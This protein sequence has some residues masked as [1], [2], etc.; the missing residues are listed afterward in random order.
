MVAQQGGSITYQ[1]QTDVLLGRSG[2]EQRVSILPKPRQRYEFTTRLTDAQQRAVL[3]TLG[4]LGQTAPV[5]LLGLS[6]EAEAVAS[7]S[8]AAVSLY[9][10][11]F[12]SSDWC[13]VGQRVAV[14]SPAGV[15]GES[16]ISSASTPT[17]T[18]DDDLSALCGPGAIIM[19]IVGVRLDANQS[20]PR[21]QNELTDWKVSAWA[22]RFRYG[23]SG[24]VGVG[25]SLTMFDSLP[26]WDRGVL[27]EGQR[28]EQILTGADLVD[29]GGKVA[30]IG[31]FDQAQWTRSLDFTSSN[32]DDWQWLKLFLDTIRGSWKSFLLR[33]YRPD[34]V[35]IGDASGGTLT[36][37]TSVQS[38]S[39]SWYPSLAHRRLAIVLSD[40]TVNYRSVA[41][42]GGGGATEDLVLS[43]ALAGTIA[44][45]EFLETV[46]LA[47]DEAAVSWRGRVF[48]TQ[49]DAV[50]VQQ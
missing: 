42:V 39:D 25:S 24:T 19:P 11:A 32:R 33:T 26:V 48:D 7:A 49:M 6:F 1:W 16:W 30:A 27:V 4:R 15:I 2:L 46:R 12:D 43:S 20:L 10:L 40:G 50:V 13:V 36:I 23:A 3:S 9:A 38:Y 18:L 8:G 21:Y 44:R 14:V 35:A 22:D 41:S 17:V 47:S 37:D 31:E 34:L 28:Q 5:F 29:L 45:V